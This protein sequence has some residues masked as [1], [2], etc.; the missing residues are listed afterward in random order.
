[1][2]NAPTLSPTKFPTVSPTEP[3]T[4]TTTTAQPTQ[5]PLDDIDEQEPIPTCVD[6]ETSLIMA[7]FKITH[8]MHKPPKFDQPYFES[9]YFNPSDPTKSFPKFI[10]DAMDAITIIGNYQIFP[11]D[12]AIKKSDWRVSYLYSNPSWRRRRLQNQY[13]ATTSEDDMEEVDS[14]TEVYFYMELTFQ[15]TKDREIFYN[16]IFNGDFSENVESR[17]CAI[18]SRWETWKTERETAEREQIAGNPEYI[19]IDV[20]LLEEIDYC[21]KPPKLKEPYAPWEPRV[22]DFN[23]YEIERS[24]YLYTTFM[25]IEGQLSVDLNFFNETKYETEQYYYDM[26]PLF[27]TAMYDCI[28]SK[29]LWSGSVVFTSPLDLRLNDWRLSFEAIEF[30][31]LEDE[32]EEDLPEMKPTRLIDYRMQSNLNSVDSVTELRRWPVI[33][34]IKSCVLNAMSFGDGIFLTMKTSPITGFDNS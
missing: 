1:M 12:N 21:S 10:K 19:G 20:P 24:C 15:N 17:A 5:F 29:L 11:N 14:Q 22:F 31:S 4:Q 13:L 23:V 6:D 26:R 27:K 7:L 30:G 28:N 8:S 25:E 9:A 33:E 32:Q 3:P 18:D 2:T 34:D 16:A